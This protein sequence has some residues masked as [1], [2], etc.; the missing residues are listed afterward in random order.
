MIRDKNI[1]F[2]ILYKTLI[3]F[4]ACM[5]QMYI[6]HFQEKGCVMEVCDWMVERPQR[7]ATF[8]G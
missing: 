7:K 2:I 6:Y 8:D 5:L 1:Y 3:H 4:L